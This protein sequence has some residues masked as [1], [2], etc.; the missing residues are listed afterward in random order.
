MTTLTHQFKGPLNQW[1]KKSI[2]PGPV[3]SVGDTLTDVRIK[4]S[5]PDMEFAYNKKF[6]PENS[7]LRGSNVQD[8]QWYSFSTHGYNAKVKTKSLN[9]AGTF[10]TPIGWRQQNIIPAAREMEPLLNKQPRHVWKNQVAEIVSRQGDMFSSLP[11]GYTSNGVLTRGGAFPSKV[12]SHSGSSLDM[13]LPN[14]FDVIDSVIM[15]SR[16]IKAE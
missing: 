10:Q 16:P 9:R 5:M 1:D 8:G 15:S 7:M 6:K 13:R 2:R 14:S 12:S 4:Q 11:M 3:G